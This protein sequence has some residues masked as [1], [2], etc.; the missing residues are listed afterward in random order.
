MEKEIN[1]RGIKKENVQ[2]VKCESI[3]VVFD[4]FLFVIILP[5]V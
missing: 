3:S 4:V 1:Q 5:P 2:E